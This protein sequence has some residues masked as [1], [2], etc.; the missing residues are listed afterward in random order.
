[1]RIEQLQQIIQTDNKKSIS[2][3]A[4][5]LSISQPQLSN[6][7]KNLEAKLGYKIFRRN[8]AGLMPT[9]QGNEVLKLAREL[10]T[11]VE[12]M[13]M[14]ASD[15]ADL[16]G[17]LSLSLGSAFFNAFASKLLIR[18]YQK[19]PNVKLVITEASAHDVIEK[20]AT[21]TCLL[22]VTGWRNDQNNA[23]QQIMDGRNIAYEE[24]IKDEFA[25]I[26]GNQHPLTTKKIVRL[27]D[28]EEVTIIDYLGITEK[29]LR[30]SGFRPK[31]NQSIKVYDREVLKY[32][33]SVN[34]GIAI[35]PRFFSLNDL[36]FER[37]L[38][39][40]REIEDL[41]GKIKVT[42]FI[43]YSK[44]EP[45]SFLDKQLIEMIKESVISDH[46]SNVTGEM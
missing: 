11:N 12:A 18:F 40:F 36:Y 9:C 35:A 37:G 13:K 41:T 19:Y 1:M 31:E 20:V 33:I 24:V 34:R 21:R 8:K 7:L 27:S 14:I 4:K 17:N 42:M 10:I 39:N 22:G 46:R 2:E 6:S 43:I 23:M 5:S 25:V 44:S 32:M 29:F 45:L 3:A 16:V 15:E 26:V 30:I 38:L 28:L